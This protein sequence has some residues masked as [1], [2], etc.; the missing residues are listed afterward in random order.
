MVLVRS[1]FVPGPTNV[2][3]AV[4]KA[5]DVP[6][7]DHR[8]PDL[9]KFILPLFED[10][11]K[12]FKTESGQVFLFPASGTGGWEAAMT[13]TLNPGDKVLA[14][15]FGQFS[16]LWISLCERLGLVVQVVECEWGTGVPS[17]T[18]GEILAADKTH[19]I[20]AVL[21]TQNET[22]TGVKSDIAN[23]RVA[24]DEAKHPAMLYVDGVSSIAS[25]DFQLDNWGVDLAVSGSQKGF[26]L[27]AGLAILCF[28]KKALAM[29]KTAECK[30]CFLD[31]Q[32]H[33]NT[34]KD[35]FFPYTPP[36]NL[37][38]GLRVAIDLLLEEG[39]ENVFIRHN[40]LASGV[41]AAIKAWGLKLAASSPK[42]QSD[43]VSAI[44]LEPGSKNNPNGKK[45]IEVINI[46]YHRYN[47]S[48]GAGLTQVAGK[49]F[50]IGHLGDNNE[51]RMMAAL[52]AVEMA[53]ID[54]GIK[55]TPGSGT[56]AAAKYWTSNPN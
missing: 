11:K 26:M 34:N 38:R 50:R 48:L 3:D 27:P 35:G 20:K 8:A 56:G 46:A 17:E 42:W 37:L 51:A 14:A 25:V 19:S 9:P 10:L 49:V 12:I 13:N 1:L 4:R 16:H 36:V 53:M 22:A 32:D 29:R 15:R 55:F 5:I 47:I 18:F 54:A 28:S 2:P 44:W 7:E 31:I 45:A 43:T 24:M 6:M 33:I 23:L 30:R 39:M 41:R 21:A 52:G 40:R